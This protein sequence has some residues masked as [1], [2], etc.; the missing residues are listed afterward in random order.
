MKN[1]INADLFAVFFLAVL[2]RIVRDSPSTANERASALGSTVGQRISDDFFA[3]FAIYE[4]IDD[5]RVEGCIAL[6]FKHYFDTVVE[7]R[8]GRIIVD[9]AYGKLG[10][11]CG[12]WFFSGVLG[13][14]FD[15][16]GGRVLFGVADGCVTFKIHSTELGY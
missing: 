15:Y 13:S 6:F 1:E 16:L 9:E 2:R 11:D 3:R 7:I 5:S 10:G 12:A 4:K 14:V 8:E